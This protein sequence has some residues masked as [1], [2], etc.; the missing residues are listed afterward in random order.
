[1]DEE[2]I[3][4]SLTMKG[5]GTLQSLDELSQFGKIFFYSC[6]HLLEKPPGLEPHKHKNTLHTFK[7]LSE[8]KNICVLKKEVLHILT[9]FVDSKGSLINKK[10]KRVISMINQHIE[11]N[12]KPRK[13]E[14]STPKVPAIRIV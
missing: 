3:L 7:V 12:K 8:N 1:M 13:D 9:N 10:K 6:V 11:S 5:D 14:E 4:K 2:A